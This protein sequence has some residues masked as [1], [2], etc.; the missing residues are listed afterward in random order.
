M[1][2]ELTNE[3]A[4]QLLMIPKWVVGGGARAMA[5]VSEQ[6][7]PAGGG[8][9]R[10]DLSLL[11]EDGGNRFILSMKSSDK[12]TLK[13]SVHHGVNPGNHVGLLRVDYSGKHFNPD[14]ALDDVPARFHQFAGMFFGYGD[15]HIH[16]YVAGYAMKWAVPLS[17]DE[18]PVKK[19]ENA[20]QIP[21]AIRAFGEA[22]ALQ[23]SLVPEPS[24]LFS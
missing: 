23:T 21:D 19:I 2:D 10:R 11:S 20:G 5:R 13:L 12:Q 17:S 8:F 3:Q 24:N 16:H 4:A 6:T 15:P 22:I 1:S 7:I 9:S 14:V 18:F